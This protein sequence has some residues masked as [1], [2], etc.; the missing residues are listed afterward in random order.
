MV[1]QLRYVFLSNKRNDYWSF[2]TYYQRFTV[3]NKLTLF[4][5]FTHQNHRNNIG[6]VYKICT[7]RISV[8]GNSRLIFL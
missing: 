8:W 5:D 6:I 1:N 7:D 4:Y 2:C 3:D